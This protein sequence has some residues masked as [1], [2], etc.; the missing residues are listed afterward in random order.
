MS[1]TQEE[2]SR[3]AV[4]KLGAH[5]HIDGGGH[6]SRECRQKKGLSLRRY[7]LINAHQQNL[8]N[9]EKHKIKKKIVS[10]ILL[11]P[12]NKHC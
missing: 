8:E 4:I 9:T 2:R 3:L 7:Q 11:P 10:P 6:V 5:Q 12:K 1:E